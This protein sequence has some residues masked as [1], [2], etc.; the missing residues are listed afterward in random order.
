M[1]QGNVRKLSTW[2]QCV[3]ELRVK[4]CRFR[5]RRIP[6]S[7]CI[8][9]R[10]Y[11]GG[12]VVRDFSVKPYRHDDDAHVALIRDRCLKAHESGRWPSEAEAVPGEAVPNLTWATLATLCRRDIEA[13][14]VKEGSRV[15]AVNHLVKVI[16]RFSGPVSARRLEEW[17][18]EISP[19]EKL[20][21]FN[22]R[23]ETLSQM[24]KA[25]VLDLSETLSRLR[26]LRPKG[27]A[28]KIRKASSQKVR[29]IPADAELEAWLDQLEPFL[30][31]VFATIATY[32]L[33]PHELW[34]A[35]GIDEDGWL[36]IPGDLRTKTSR[37]FAPPVPAG[38]LSRYELAGN[39]ERFHG[40]LNRRWP[41][42][43]KEV[44]GV[45]IA[46]NNTAVSNYLYKAFQLSGLQKLW[47]PKAEG[48]G[49]DWCRPYDLRHAYAIRCASS[50]ETGESVDEEMARWMGHS[51][52]VHK[53]I[54]L[55]WLSSSREKESL[56]R[57]HT[58]RA[59]AAPQAEGAPVHEPSAGS[60]LPEGITPE[61]IAMALKLKAAGLG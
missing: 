32:G 61:L 8:Y 48:E 40:E 58:M 21:Q 44:S 51:V 59:A 2:D 34:H 14:I 36:T 45:Q 39:W 43:W 24:N 56:K 28:E 33:R 54:Y 12:R 23:I 29:V 52:D 42:R 57:R 1:A 17:V 16:G 13:R 55:R 4:G 22:R 60:G 19:V 27:A 11:L 15:H 25:G 3:H 7:D 53:R 35:E 30:Q 41:V 26:A 47:A 18:L 46:V 20:H 9:V 38:W 5:I 50:A 49:V 10:E 31:W 6:R 37:H